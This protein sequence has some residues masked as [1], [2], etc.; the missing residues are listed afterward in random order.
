MII[1]IFA[2]RRFRKKP[3]EVVEDSGKEDN[4]ELDGQENEKGE[5]HGTE[6]LELSAPPGYEMEGTPK[7]ELDTTWPQELPA[8]PVRNG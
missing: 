5:I 8:E 7:A 4:R 6:V 3:D 2:I 1:A